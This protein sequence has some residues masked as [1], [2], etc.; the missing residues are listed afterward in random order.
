MNWEAIGAIGEL[1]SGAAVIATLLYLAIQ[2]KETRK[3]ALA[4][5]YQSR[6]AIRQ[7]N[8]LTVARSDEFAALFT[9]IESDNGVGFDPAK[10]SDLS[11][12]EQIRLRAHLISILVSIDNTLYQHSLGLIENE[13]FAHAKVAMENYLVLWRA[14]DPIEYELPATVRQIASE[15]GLLEPSA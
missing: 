1:V 15:M 11:R 9:R 8:H 7:Q 13:M 14:T 12:T 10:V 2:V 4:A 5:T 6:A 3:V